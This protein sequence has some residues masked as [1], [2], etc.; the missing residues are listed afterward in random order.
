MLCDLEKILWRG[1]RGLTKDVCIKGLARFI[2]H[3]HGFDFCCQSGTAVH[4][5][6]NYS[7]FSCNVI[8]D[9][10]SCDQR[11]RAYASSAAL[12]CPVKT[13]VRAYLKD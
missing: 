2:R 12:S 9:F 3:H 13:I 4:Q 10:L 6:T 1:K 8:Q 7:M 11:S 5:N